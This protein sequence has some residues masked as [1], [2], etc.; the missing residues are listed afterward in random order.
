MN[1]RG[2]HFLK[3]HACPVCAGTDLAPVYAASYDADP[4][5]GF[6]DS[7][8]RDQGRIDWSL[9]AGAT[10]RILVCATCDL[11]F[12]ASVPDDALL[13][14][15]YSEMIDPELLARVER[16]LLTLEGFDKVAGELGVLF[17]L[18]GKPPAEISFLDHGFGFGRF[19]RVARAMGATVYATELG[20]EKRR[21]AASLGVEII[22][23]DAIDRMTFDIVHTE[24]VL[25]HVREPGAEFARLAR[26]ARSV[27][28]TAVPARR[29]ARAL[30]ER[31]GLP[32][33]SPYARAQRGLPPQKDDDAFISVQPLEHLNAFSARTMRWLGDRNGME[34]VSRVRMGTVGVDLSSARLLAKS[35]GRLGRMVGKAVLR[36]D[37]GYFLFRPKPG[38]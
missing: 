10:F 35:V 1:E 18:T 26:A 4:V 23:D 32:A 25:E 27:L 33:Q 14:H 15:L 11:L 7:H 36:P 19:A 31:R 21:S 12:Q 13:R 22:E 24:Q 2:S 37:N 16:G 34:L 17:G 20:E 38:R 8:Y 5:R 6:L 30:L 29:N 28:K 9:L 3:R